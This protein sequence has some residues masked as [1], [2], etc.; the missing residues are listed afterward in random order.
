MAKSHLLLIGSLILNTAIAVGCA[1]G[2][3][4][5]NNQVVLHRQEAV[6]LRAAAQYY[7]EEAQRSVQEAGQDSERARRYRAFAEQASVQ[8]KEADRLA[9]EYQQQ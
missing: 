3:N 8:A 9:E 7:E 1:N 5:P 4:S 2:Y 6:D